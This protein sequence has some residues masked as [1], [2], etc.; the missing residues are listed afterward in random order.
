MTCLAL[1][2]THHTIADLMPALKCFA[3][4]LTRSTDAADELVQKAYERALS[5]PQSL[6]AVEEPAKWMRRIIRNLWIDEKRSARDRLS[7]PLEGEDHV[8]PEDTERTVIARTTLA[9]VR[10]VMAALPEDQRSVLMLICVEGL[11]Y[12]QAAAVLGIPIGT[13]MSRLYRGRLELAQRLSLPNQGNAARNYA[14][15]SI[16]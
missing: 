7:E 6:A 5:N 4:S 8:A 1:Q 13:V 10:T 9:R 2:D 11:S 15:A 16:Y 14:P 12:Q 3:R